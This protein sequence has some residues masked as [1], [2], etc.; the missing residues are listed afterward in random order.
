M[1]CEA[2][3][4]LERE[5]RLQ[6]LSDNQQCRLEA[7][8]VHASSRINR[9]RG[10]VEPLRLHRREGYAS[11]RIII[12]RRML[13]IVGERELRLHSE[14]HDIVLRCMILIYIIIHVY[15]YSSN[16]IYTII[17]LCIYIHLPVLYTCLGSVDNSHNNL[18]FAHLISHVCEVPLADESEFDTEEL[19]EATEAP[20]PLWLT[21]TL[22]NRRTA[23]PI[24]PPLVCVALLECDV[25][26]VQSATLLTLA[27]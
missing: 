14:S 17:I 13:S 5:E 2:L 23:L 6:Q 27:P 12:T 22:Q 7:E 4:T 8:T 26:A 24:Q 25:A 10:N 21:Q 1:R 20:T 3:S 11:S 19:W 15:I 16:C 18:N 9:I